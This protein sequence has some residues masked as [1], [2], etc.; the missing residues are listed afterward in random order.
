MRG[1]QAPHF[2]LTLAGPE[3]ANSTHS[4][5]LPA[6]GTFPAGSLPGGWLPTVFSAGTQKLYGSWGF[7]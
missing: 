6:K 7:E 3:L 2:S 4:F 5:F 1:E